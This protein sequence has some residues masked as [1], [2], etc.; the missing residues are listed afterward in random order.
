[1]KPAA[2]I[3]GMIRRWGP[4]VTCIALAL[5]LAVI[6]LTLCG[7]CSPDGRY[8]TL[9]FFFDGVPDPHAPPGSAAARGEKD[10]FAPNA[11]VQKVYLHKP[12]ADGMKDEKKCQVCHVGASGGF[13]NFT[14]VSSNVCLKCH[15]D[16]LTQYPVMHGPVAAVECTF[17]HAAHESTIPGMLNWEAPRVCVQCHTQDLLS[18]KPPEHLLP[19]SKCLTCHSGH[20]GPKHKMLRADLAAATATTRPAPAG[21]NPPGGGA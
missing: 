3:S 4:A 10:E 13:E 16:K 21:K 12:Y 11:V 6:G 7:G 5:L 2:P 18:A 8:K 17:C 9:S 15:K 14:S 19:D 20:G 1:M